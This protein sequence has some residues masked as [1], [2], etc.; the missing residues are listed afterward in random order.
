M[1]SAPG[2]Y[3]APVGKTS[4][5]LEWAFLP[6]NLRAFI[7]RKCGSPVVEAISQTSGFTPG[8]ASVLVCADGSRHFV[9]AASVKAQ[10]AFA[11]SYREEARKLA[12]LP[13]GVPS[14]RLLWHL[15]DDWVALGIEYVDGRAP[16]RPWRRA[17]LD[18]VLDALEV[19]ADEL[20]P[21]PAGLDLDTLADDFVDMV[22]MWDHLKAVR[23]DLPHLDEAAALAAGFADVVGGTTLIHTDIRDDNLL[24]DAARKV[25]LCDWN[26]PVVGA[27]WID[28]ILTLIGPRGDG[29]DVEPVL[30]S[31]RLTRDVPPEAIDRVLALLVGYFLKSA[32]DPVPATSPFLREHQRWQ[33]DVCWHWLSERRG[34]Q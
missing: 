6:P 8:F 31:R 4:H 14:P 13:T 34:W 27:A 30:A 23:P 9:K 16:R 32:D 26:W 10:R 21:P 24:V 7:E 25:W 3:P 19:V 11:D 17:D 29:I 5:R 2:P 15:D 12:A 22:S 1:P 33:G 20:T 28:T 18:T